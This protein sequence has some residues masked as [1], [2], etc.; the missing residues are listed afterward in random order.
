LGCNRLSAAAAE[1]DCPQDFA[2]GSALVWLMDARI[3]REIFQL[4][5]VKM[6]TVTATARWSK[7]YL[8]VGIADFS[9][10]ER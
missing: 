8:A 2:R 4:G 3:A 6:N 5:L 10:P 9:L 1:N 7:D